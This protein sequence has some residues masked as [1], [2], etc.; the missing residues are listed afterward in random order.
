MNIYICMHTHARAHTHTCTHTHIRTASCPWA[1][2]VLCMS[3]SPRMS[4]VHIRCCSYV[5]THAYVTTYRC[6]H[7][8]QPGGY[9]ERCVPPPT[10]V[11]T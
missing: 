11:T 2:H 5:R 1:Q 10:D 3:Y 7:M 4:T 6:D 8:N 9:G